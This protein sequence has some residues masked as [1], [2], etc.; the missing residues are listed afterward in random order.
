MICQ[1]LN[2]YLWY[3]RIQINLFYFAKYCHVL[4]IKS[5]LK[6]ILTIGMF[7]SLGSETWDKQKIAKQDTWSYHSS[8]L[9]FFI[10]FLTTSD[11]ESLLIQGINRERVEQMEFRLKE[12]IL[13]EASR[14][15]NCEL[16]M[17][18]I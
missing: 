9:I 11:A 4:V 1:M 15:I 10:F 16:T 12:D 17:Q 13:Q 18:S 6:S 2:L 8:L 5:E 3:V 7:F 14:Y